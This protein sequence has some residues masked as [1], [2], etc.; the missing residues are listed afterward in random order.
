MQRTRTTLLPIA[1]AASTVAAAPT[2]SAQ[3]ARIPTS[4]QLAATP[5]EGALTLEQAIAVALENN[6]EIAAGSHALA[7]ADLA[8]A[9]ARSHRLPKVSVEALGAQSITRLGVDFPAGAFGVFDGIGPVPA[10]DTRVTSPRRPLMLTQATLTQPISQL[11]RINVNVKATAVGRDIEREQLRQTMQR[12]AADV[13]RAYYALLQVDAGLRAAEAVVEASRALD[14][15]VGERVVQRVALRGDGLQSQVRVAEAVQQRLVLQ[16]S[17]AERQEQFNLLLGRDP[18]RPVAVVPMAIADDPEVDLE[19]VIREAIER[20][21][22]VR[23]ARLEVERAELRQQATI[24]GRIPD[25][26]LAMSYQSFFNSD[27]LPRNM[28]SVGVQATWEPWDWGR[29]LR[30][31]RQ[32]GHD[33]E[34]ARLMLRQ[35]EDQVRIEVARSYRDIQQARGQVLLARASQEVARDHLR[36]TTERIKVAAALPVDGLTANRELAEAAAREQEALSG[37][38]AARAAYEQAIGEDVR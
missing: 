22:D 37:Y 27:L 16:N 9:T 12:T 25:V 21:A 32:N 15:V 7:G 1:L 13:R 8:V 23:A 28:A 20:R 38:W 30:E 18:H 36:V 17:R 33:V 11:F 10:V 14:G 29:R 34:R 3:E 19:V 26:S 24:A 6:R 35:A 2:A 4:A 5:G 31:A